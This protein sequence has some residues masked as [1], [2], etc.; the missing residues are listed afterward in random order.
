MN[1]MKRK[2]FLGTVTLMV[3]IILFVCIGQVEVYAGTTSVAKAKITQC[4]GAYNKEK[5]CPKITLKWKKVKGATG[6][7]VYM[8]SPREDGKYTKIKTTS[9]ISC[10]KQM[11]YLGYSEKTMPL[12]IDVNYSFKVRAY[13]K[14]KG[15][16][17][18]GKFS[19][20]KNISLESVSYNGRLIRSAYYRLLQGVKFPNSVTINSIRI[21]LKTDHDNPRYSTLTGGEIANRIIYFDYT[22]KNGYNQDRRGF[23]RAVFIP[24]VD[25]PDT[26][27]WNTTFTNQIS[28]GDFVFS[29]DEYLDMVNNLTYIWV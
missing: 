22:A 19:T 20:T 21:G 6:Y 27:E 13:K 28:N 11:V 12:R 2:L 7:Q 3:C 10:I 26:G 29:F 5:H 18:Y 8:T 1:V 24:S 17:H 15:K 16:I 9:N 23:F 14:V 25:A 4:T